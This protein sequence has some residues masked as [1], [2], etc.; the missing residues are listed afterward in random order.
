[1]IPGLQ[2]LFASSPVATK[3]T[4]L[5]QVVSASLN[6]IFYI[7]SFLAFIWLV[8]GAFQYI[9]A[10]GDKEKLARARS[11]ITWAIIGLILVLLAFLVAQFT[12]QI[13]QPRTGTTI[14]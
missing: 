7:A 10:G 6:I 5:G 12:A 9:F 11:R 2:E 1:M 8:W 4:N 3:F 13:L 14:L